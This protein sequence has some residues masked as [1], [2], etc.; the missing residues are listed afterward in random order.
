ME[1]R[2]LIFLILLFSG[3]NLLSAQKDM[4]HFLLEKFEEGEVYH[5][6]GAFSKE[7]LNY[8]IVTGKFCFLSEDG[9][10]TKILDV[11]KVYLIKIGDRTF[12]PENDKGIEILSTDPAIYVQYNANVQAGK[13]KG[14]YGMNTEAASI[15]HYSG[16]SGDGQHSVVEVNKGEISKLY[17]VY[18]IERNGQKKTF[19]SFKQF[20]KI[21][22]KHKGI[23][24]NYIQENKINFED[25][26]M[27]R[28]LCFYAESL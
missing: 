22:P 9:M 18:W 6:G 16:F 2:N 28:K 21:Y 3:V 25:V 4:S 15:D 27:I 24:E 7:K 14:P 12:Y 20:M 19:K 26:D 23:L 17:N 11:D 13:V 5:K 10:S 1:C 8:N